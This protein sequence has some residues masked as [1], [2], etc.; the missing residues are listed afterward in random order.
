VRISKNQS[1]D[2]YDA[3][4]LGAGISGLVACSIVLQDGASNLK[5]I[6]SYKHI[7]G[8]HINVDIGEY[9]FDIGSFIF[10]DDSPLL[11]H[12][13]EL[14]AYYIEIDPSWQ[15]L[16][17]Q[18]V[19]TKY[20]FSVKD[21]LISA[22]PIE[23][24]RIGASVAISRMFRRNMKNARDFARYWI[25]TRLLKRSGLEN[26]MERFYGLPAQRIELKFAEKRMSWI[27]EY[28]SLNNPMLKRRRNNEQFPTNRQLVRPKEG[29]DRLYK[30]AGDKLES[31]GVDIALETSVNSIKKVDGLFEV[32]CAGTTLYTRRV[33]STLPLRNSL[34]LCGI[35]PGVH[36]Q[37]VRLLSLFYSFSG[38]RGFPSSI[39]YNFSF[40]GPW[41][42]LTVYS[43]FYGTANGREYFGVEVNADNVAGS[44]DIADKRFREHVEAN[45][46]FI[47]D[48]VLEG[49]TITSDAYPIYVDGATELAQKAVRALA[50]F[51]VE[52]IGRQGRFDYQPTARDTTLKAEMAL[53]GK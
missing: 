23:W 6:D 52:S 21:D 5:L 13:P 46:L 18:G 17:P 37:S 19:V 29:F 3:V 38:Q 35:D 2:V 15:R 25:G 33:I 39:L 51:G 16:N 50:E 26:Y 11:R 40:L 53:S 44:A 14:L 10:Q 31:L 30:V 7:G 8:N 27:S 20:P 41:K 49:S 43:D 45:S 42:R 28:A 1:D 32:Q 12:F 9:S 4:I 48:L 47:G 22:G 24:A 36:L 34:A